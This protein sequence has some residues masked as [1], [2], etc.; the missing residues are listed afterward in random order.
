MRALDLSNRTRIVGQL[1]SVQVGTVEI[2]YISAHLAYEMMVFCDIGI[3]AGGIAYRTNPGDNTLVFKHP[4]CSVD[5]IE[6]YRR[7]LLSDTF[8]YFFS[9]GVTICLRERPHNLQSLLGSLYAISSALLA[10]NL[11]V[12][13]HLIS[14]TREYKKTNPLPCFTAMKHAFANIP[15]P[16]NDYYLRQA[17]LLPDSGQA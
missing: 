10:E 4:Q 6:R 14:P 13:L 8:E 7:Q 9:I 5:C 1:N 11:E 3:E 15:T 2:A 16:S 17:K 12:I